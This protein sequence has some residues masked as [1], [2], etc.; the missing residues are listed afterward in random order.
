MTVMI[1]IAAIAGIKI[2][3]TLPALFI[4]FSAK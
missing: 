3:N 1:S 2:A 4:D